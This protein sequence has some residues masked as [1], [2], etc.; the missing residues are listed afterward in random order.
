MSEELLRELIG[1]VKAMRKSMEQKATIPQELFDR[2]D[3]AA[4]LNISIAKLGALAAEK[5]IKYAKLGDG[6][7]AKVL[8]RKKDLDDFVAR[9]CLMT[10]DEALV[11]V[12][13]NGS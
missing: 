2:E 12:A 3:A 11:K 1:E 4:Y 9:H 8:Y 13:R 5:A 6:A 7:T 10:R